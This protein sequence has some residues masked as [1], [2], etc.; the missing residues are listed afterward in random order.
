MSEQKNAREQVVILAEEGKYLTFALGREEYGLEILKVR[1]IIGLMEITGVPQMPVYVKGVSG[2]TILGDGR[3]G[4]IIDVNGIVEAA[5][6]MD[7]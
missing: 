5:R 4:L 7:G 3:V 2:A 1:E 6:K